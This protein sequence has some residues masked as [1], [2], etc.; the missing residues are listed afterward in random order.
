MSICDLCGRETYYLRPSKF[1]KRKTRKKTS[2]P[3]QRMCSTCK[4]WES[5]VIIFLLVWLVLGLSAVIIFGIRNPHPP[6]S[7]FYYFIMA[8]AAWGLPLIIV[9]PGIQYM[10]ARQ[11]VADSDLS[12]LS[13]G[14]LLTAL[15]SVRT[16][17]DSWQSGEELLKVYRQEARNIGEELNKRGGKSLMTRAYRESGATRSIEIS[18]DGIGE[19]RG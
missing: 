15:Q 8:A 2:P 16:K 6:I 9:P 11:S 12:A 4:Q 1:Y 5:R 18:W 14:D 3:V 17:L 7:Y 10:R 19:W 13:Y